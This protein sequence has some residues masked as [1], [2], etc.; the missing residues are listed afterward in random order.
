MSAAPGASI[1]VRFQRLGFRHVVFQCGGT[2]FVR[3]WPEAGLSWQVTLEDRIVAPDDP[4]QRVAMVTTKAAGGGGWCTTTCAD[5]L[6]T[7]ELDRATVLEQR[8]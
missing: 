5:L 2:G 6:A 7:M 3:D 1:A 4:Q 8:K